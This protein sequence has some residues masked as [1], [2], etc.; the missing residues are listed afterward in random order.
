MK[1]NF[2]LQLSSQSRNC[3]I[4]LCF[5][6]QRLSQI[7]T[8]CSTFSAVKKLK[9]NSLDG[10]LSFKSTNSSSQH[11]RVRKPLF[12]LNLSRPFPLTPPAPPSTPNFHMNISFTL[13]RT[14]L[15]T[16]TSS[17]TSKLKILVTTFHEMIVD[18]FAI[19]PPATLSS[20]TSYTGG[21]STPFFVDA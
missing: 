20:E 18:V 11:L 2:L 1:R 10:S 13:L 4:T 7:P 6:P 5:A 17:S 12:S 8:L 16:V 15:G 19:R 14:I 21:A 3:A 9:A